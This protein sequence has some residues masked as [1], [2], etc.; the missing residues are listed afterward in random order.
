MAVSAPLCEPCP[1]SVGAEAGLPDVGPAPPGRPW[2]MPPADFA[3]HVPIQNGGVVPAPAELARLD[4]GRRQQSMMISV[5]A[6]ELAVRP[7]RQLVNCI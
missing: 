2:Q 5:V 1:P 6:V 4:R 3:Q 7:A